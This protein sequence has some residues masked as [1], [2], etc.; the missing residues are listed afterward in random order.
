MAM[1]SI[2][3][4]KIVGYKEWSLDDTFPPG[5]KPR[6]SRTNDKKNFLLSPCG[7]QFATR[8]KSFQFMVERG[9]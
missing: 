7:N 8:F 3:R 5:W 9:Q 2:D 4:Q 1:D 6:I